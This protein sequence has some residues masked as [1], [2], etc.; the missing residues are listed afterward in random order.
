MDNEDGYAGDAPE[1]IVV[2]DIVDAIRRKA[3]A[4]REGKYSA[5]NQCD[6]L[7]YENSEGG[8]L[9]ERGEVIRRLTRDRQTELKADVGE[10]RQ[11]HLLYGESMYLDL[12]G[13]ERLPPIDVSREYAD[14]WVDWLETQA[15]YLRERNFNALDVDN[16][17]EELDSLARADQRA[18][19][20]QLRRLLVHLL[21]WKYQQS[22]R[23]KS[24]TSSISSARDQIEE[25]LEEN[26][27]FEN[28]IDAL[29]KLEYPRAVREASRETKIGKSRFPEE[30]P[31]TVDQLRD[32]EFLPER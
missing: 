12:F 29:V 7:I 22:K 21:K 5:T 32:P 6:L 18:L 11:I 25:L 14:S 23:A 1:R 9:S 10:F 28:R 15:K 17:A 30:C 16:L 13:S 19:R 20:S 8:L 24:W 27:S 31:F 2:R 3:K 26:P 4:R